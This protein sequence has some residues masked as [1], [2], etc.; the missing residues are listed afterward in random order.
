M[1]QARFGRVLLVIGIIWLLLAVLLVAYRQIAP[2]QVE[3][4]W[5]TATEQGTAGFNIYRR[6]GSSSDFV[7][8]NDGEFIESAGSAISGADYAFTDREVTPGETYFYVLEEIETDGSRQRYED[9]VFEYEVPG[10]SWL[11]TALILFCFA[12]GVVMIVFGLKEAQR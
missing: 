2:P 7:L 1:K 4:T 9:D 11:M 10:T 8:I 6:A 12:I 3:I 5:E